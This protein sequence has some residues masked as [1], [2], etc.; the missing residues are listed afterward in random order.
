MGTVENDQK[1]FIRINTT[2]K[3]GKFVVEPK[4]VVNSESKYVMTRGGDFYAYW[5][6]RLGCWTKKEQDVIDD[7]DQMLRDYV[8]SR[9]ELVGVDVRWMRDADSGVIDKWHKLVQKQMRDNF[10]PLDETLTFANTQVTRENY[11]TKRLPYALMP[12]NC[13]AY[14]ELISTLYSKSERHKIEWAIGSVVTGDSKWIQKFYVFFGSH[15]T[16][17]STIL[18]IIEQLFDGY[19]CEFRAEEL[20]SNNSQFGM[21]AFKE[22]SLVAIQHD[23]KL[24]RIENN[25]QLNSIVSHE[26]M[27]INPKYGKKYSMRIIAALFLGTNTPVRITEAKSGLIRRLIDIRPTGITL[28]PARYRELMN[29]IPFELGAIAWHC[30]EVFE[31]AGPYYYDG[32]VPTEMISA[33][34][35]FYSFVDNYFDDFVAANQTTALEAWGKYRKW[36]EFA[37]IQYPLNYQRFRAELTNYFA[38]FIED[39]HD[40]NG[41]HI[42]SLY[43]GFL[44]DKFKN[45][46]KSYDGAD[47]DDTVD[48]LAEGSVGDAVAVMPIDIS[49][50]ENQ[51]AGWLEFGQQ[52]FSEFDRI[53]ADY[54]AQ[55]AKPDGSP[56]EPW[57]K[58]TD[59]LK[60]LDT[61][62]LHYVRVPLNHVVIDFDIPDPETGE[63]SFKLNLEAASKFKPTYAELSKSGAGIH[64]HYIYSGDPTLL[65]RNF[66]PHIEQK[67]FVGLSSLRRKLTLCNNLPITTIGSGLVLKGVQK[68]IDWGG[69]ENEK[70][71]RAI[72]KKDLKKQ[73]MGAT[74]PSIDHIYKVLDEAHVSGI[75]YDVRDMRPAVIAFASQSSHQALYCLKLVTKMQFMSEEVRENEEVRGKDRYVFFDCEVFPNLFLVNWKYDGDPDDA[76]VRWINP[77]GSDIE[78][79]VD[80]PLIGFNNRKY[81]NHILYARMM[82][83][84]NEQLYR[85]SQRIVNGD[86]DAFF[87]AAYNLSFADV[88]DF[89]ST[90]Q[91]LKKWEIELGIHHQELGLPWDQPVPEDRWDEVAVYCDNDVNATEKVF[92]DRMSDFQAREMLAE[93]SGLT[94]NDTTRQHTT[95]IIFGNDKHPQLVYTDLSE[96]F[97]GYQFVDGVNMY[98][99]E[100][101]SFGGYVYAQ[102]GVYTDVALLDVA[103]L[104][105]SSIIAMNVFGEYTPRFNDI[106]QA[107]IAIKHKDYERA[108]TM[109]DGKLAPYLGSPDDAKKLAQAL[110][111]VINSVYGYTSAKFDNPFKDPRNVNNIV[112]LRGAL[113]MVT[114]RD[115]VQARGFEVAHIKTDSIKIPNATPEIIQFCMD[116]GKKYGYNFEHQATYSRIC[117]VNDAVYIARHA[118]SDWCK[119][120]YG[121]VPEECDENDKNYSLWEATGLQFKVPYVYK[122]LFSHEPIVFDDMCETKSVTSGAIYIDF[123]EGLADGEHNYAFVGRVGRF[124]PMKPGTGGGVL[125]RVKDDK[126]AAVTGTKGWRWMESEMVSL[127]NKQ[128]DVNLDYYKAQVNDAVEAISQYTDFEWFVSDDTDANPLPDFMNIPENVNGDAVPFDDSYVVKGE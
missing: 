100:D 112:A 28:E 101:V 93:L 120:R 122:S 40:R 111:I 6:P 18:H 11:S 75:P 76:C 17:K 26:D 96:T 64:L 42:R 86:R 97:P 116:F 21:D 59:T 83:Y 70:H 72:I 15:G 90:K 119:K 16:G 20:V 80:L 58:V 24:D 55:Y 50:G 53:A 39:S 99:G 33:T 51:G 48:L 114:L 106:L 105:P 102:P 92:H 125:Y 23:S 19:R 57:D 110:K 123:D 54:P 61:H 78:K 126:Y 46:M 62:E 104:H 34:N 66:G 27:E 77:S 88:Y 71:L 63:K 103:S 4:F 8:S 91:S 95:K 87:S 113:F 115:E 43:R 84:T 79:L 56:L 94:V 60:D 7:I 13:S 118:S 12:G 38:D 29:Q 32:Y 47:A 2:A 45:R 124:C 37:G 36:V 85:L 49:K 52:E 41:K 44:A 1:D 5:A 73:I 68:V 65:D 3:G 10:V 9:P 121:Y 14:E 74:K 81:D 117:L 67:V 35:D 109:M 89:C 107:R 69:V 22:N 108:K 25:T 30:K 31:K 128:D 98:R 82:G 127:L